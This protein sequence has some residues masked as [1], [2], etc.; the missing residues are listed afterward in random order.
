VTV[1]NNILLVT[2]SP[3]GKASYSNRVAAALAQALVERNPSSHLVT[4]DLARAPLPHIDSDFVDGQLVA[5]EARTDAHIR[6]LKLSD[7][8][9]DEL[10]AADT[11]VIGTALINFMMPSTLK[12]WV[13]LLVRAGRT[14]Q[15]QDGRPVGMAG[16]KNVYVVEASGSIYSAGELAGA[17]RLE[18]WLRQ[19]LGFIGMT[20]IE[21]LK[22]E[23]IAVSPEVASAALEGALAGIPQLLDRPPRS[24]VPL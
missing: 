19:I 5:A 23:G 24:D 4:R 18:L 10:M 14:F 6:I 16:G 13:D 1:A 17:N 11:V 12:S 2:S 20:E 22:M 15:Y 21:F 7:V 3:R 9:I 8:L